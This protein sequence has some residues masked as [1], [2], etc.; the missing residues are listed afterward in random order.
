MNRRLIIS[1]TAAAILTIVLL[2]LVQSTIRDRASSASATL[3]AEIGKVRQAQ[4]VAQM[5]EVLANLAAENHLYEKSA[6]HARMHVSR[7]L[8]GNAPLGCS[9]LLKSCVQARVTI[10]MVLDNLLAEHQLAMSTL[11]TMPNV[12][13]SDL[14]KQTIV[15]VPGRRTPPVDLILKEIRKSTPFEPKI[16]MVPSGGRAAAVSMALN[17]V[18][19]SHIAFVPPGAVCTPHWMDHLLKVALQNDQRIVSPVL[20]FGQLSRTTDLTWSQLS[21]REDLTTAWVRTKQQSLEGISSPIL[22]SIHVFMV[23]VPFI[24]R[25]GALLSDIDYHGQEAAIELSIRAWLCGQG[26]VVAPCSRVQILTDTQRYPSMENIKQIAEVHFEFTLNEPNHQTSVPGLARQ[27]DQA[28]RV[29]TA[30]KST[31][32]TGE[33]AGI[34]SAEGVV[35]LPCIYM[36]YREWVPNSVGCDTLTL[37]GICTS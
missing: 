37:L 20:S 31:S 10:I 4:A 16:L 9:M 3:P 17:H 8:G 14:W 12:T 27:Q 11:Q 36:V 26:V 32:R 22:P 2:I 21:L 30:S 24:K 19:G 1:G 23:H 29:L 25:L 13:S 6:M 28:T 7:P 34:V 18:Q 5:D 35:E 33:L 15:T